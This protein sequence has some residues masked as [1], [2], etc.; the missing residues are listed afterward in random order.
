M[1]N[2]QLIHCINVQ[3]L[4]FYLYRCQ[5]A[6]QQKLPAIDGGA[7]YDIKAASKQRLS[8]VNQDSQPKDGD[9]KAFPQSGIP[10]NFNSGHI[11]EPV[12]ANGDMNN[13]VRL[14]NSKTYEKRQ[15]TV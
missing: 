10:V 7:W 5:H 3:I 2:D 15:T 8:P 6:A 1:C 14:S 9:F 13:E 12:Q 4:P 11:I